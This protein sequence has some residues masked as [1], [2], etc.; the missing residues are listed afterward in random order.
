MS[1]FSPLQAANINWQQ[2]PT[3][4]EYGDVYFMSGDYQTAIEESEKVFLQP[5]NLPARFVGQKTF[6][7]GETGFGSGLNFLVAAK[8]WLKTNEQGCLYFYSVEKHPWKYADFDQLYR[9]HPLEIYALELVKH[10]P[11]LVPGWHRLVL[12]D[13]RVELRLFFGEALVGFSDLDLRRNPV[14]AWFLDGFA[15]S[16]NPAMWSKSLFTSLRKLSKFGTTLASFTVAAQVRKNLMEAGFLVKK[17]PGFANKREMLTGQVVAERKFG[18]EHPWFDPGDA[19]LHAPCKLEKVFDVAVIGAGL[20]GAAQALVFAKA[21]YQVLVLE[22]EQNPAQKASGNQA[23]L[24]HFPLSADW[25]LRTR[26]YYQGLQTSLRYL[27]PWLEAGKISGELQGLVQ[28]VAPENQQKWQADLARLNLETDFLR[29]CEP[30]EAAELVGGKVSQAGIFYQQAGWVSPKSVVQ[31]C[32]QHENISLATDIS[33]ASVI[34][35]E[36]QQAVKLE[37]NGVTA[38]SKCVIYAV[39]EDKTL[40]RA[41]SIQARLLRGQISYLQ[42][43]NQAWLLQ[44]PL[45]YKGYVSP[46]GEG[47]AVA[48]ASYDEQDFDL[49]LRANDQQQNL[50]WAEEALP[51]WLVKPDEIAL[52]GRA[53]IRVSTKDHLPLVGAVADLGALHHSFFQYSSNQSPFKF[54]PVNYCRNAYL[55]NGHGS[56]GLTSVFLAAEILFAQIT[57]KPIPVPVSLYN[58]ALP[59]RF[60]VKEWLKQQ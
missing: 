25:S 26:W 7:I 46:A 55:S 1:S 9:N 36:N 42:P 40:N 56:R 5:N 29:W 31:A 8:H 33:L 23:G 20:A 57:G 6:S 49:N 28:L 14:D 50:A 16:K 30:K 21:G 34:F 35:E 13:G 32:L 37:F 17:T 18:F 4:D 19:I 15:P 60:A 10:Y 2:V 59:A 43:H 58:A 12:F 27:Q 51:H 53:A 41:T 24:V 45:L 48:G 11:Q 39:G 47:N 3:S 44:K 38:F 52:S 22:K 54:A